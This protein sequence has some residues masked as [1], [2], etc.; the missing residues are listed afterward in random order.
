ML[1]KKSGKSWSGFSSRCSGYGKKDSLMKLNLIFISMLI[2]LA[3]EAQR[4]SGRVINEATGEPLVYASIG[5][6]GTG[7]GT[8]TDENGFFSIIAKDLPPDAKIRF[9]MI[10]FTAQTFSFAGLQENENLVIKLK[11]EVRYL[12]NVSIAS[13]KFETK[14]IGCKA[15][16]KKIVTGWSNVGRGGERGIKIKIKNKPVLLKSFHVHIARN[17]FDSVLFRLHIRNIRNNVPAEELLKDNIIF[18]V[19]KKSGW[20]V[21]DLTGYN[22]QYDEDFAVTLE[23]VKSWG[24]CA[25]I[26]EGCLYISMD[27]FGGVLFVK[28]AGEATWIVENKYRPGMYLTVYQ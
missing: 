20:V 18:T 19:S 16:S 24:I 7:F 27:I 4:I 28:H 15:T 22:L 5:V 17:A 12:E 9:S 8:T 1:I 13:T 26:K 11:E 23:W 10:G 21:L 14:E 3:A 25:N 6:V 2:C